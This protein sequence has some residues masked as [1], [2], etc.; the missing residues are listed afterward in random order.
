MFRYFPGYPEGAAFAEKPCY[1]C[2]ACPALDGELLDFDEAFNDPPPV[3]L[4]DFLAGKARMD[5][6][7]S[8]QRTLARNV[9]ARHP[10][11]NEQARET[12]VQ[13][14]TEEL[15]H[16]PPVSW[17]QPN[18][19]PV[20]GGDYAQF[21]GELTRARI[22]AHAGSVEGGKIFLQTILRQERPE[23][24]GDSWLERY[25]EYL[26]DFMRIYQFRCPDGSEVNVLQMM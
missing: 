3:C 22:E 5:I 6:P 8:I 24:P 26:G 10:D 19:W 2:G 18:Q 17:I 11:W 1:F 4:P 12:Y 15:A 21:I 20:C 16:T 25:W 13:E 7:S 14:R 9:E 23:W